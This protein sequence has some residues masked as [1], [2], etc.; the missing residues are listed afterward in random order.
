M[1]NQKYF[2]CYLTDHSGFLIVSNMGNF[3]N[4]HLKP[5]RD[6]KKDFVKHHLVDFADEV[7]SELIKNN[8]LK[9]EN[10]SLIESG[11]SQKIYRVSYYCVSS[12]LYNGSIKQDYQE[13]NPVN[14]L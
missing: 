9:I 4:P 13:T 5:I 1:E 12:E 2:R 14:I 11:C 3:S 7:S 8:I 6:R 10:C